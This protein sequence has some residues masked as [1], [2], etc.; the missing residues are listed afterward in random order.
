[1]KKLFFIILVITSIYSNA[2]INSYR[3][4]SKI[5]TKWLNDEQINLKIEEGNNNG[6]KWNK[7]YVNNIEINCNLVECWSKNNNEKCNQI[8]NIIE[9]QKQKINQTQYK[10][11]TNNKSNYYIKNNISNKTIYL[12][13]QIYVTYILYINKK[14]LSRDFFNQ[15]QRPQPH[16]LKI[17]EF[18]GFW[19]N[20]EE[21]TTE[22]KE[23]GE[24]IKLTLFRGVLTAKKTGELI[25][26]PPPP[27]L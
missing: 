12:G 26:N 14:I 11:I 24:Y 1:M 21:T 20:K 16:S 23:D 9:S 18:N 19:V 2:Q 22:F 7:C 8:L 13:E 4:S 3:S 15:L 27:T 6:E 17:P 5:I 10:K 25:I